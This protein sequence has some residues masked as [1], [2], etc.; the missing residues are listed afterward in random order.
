MLPRVHSVVEM[1]LY[2][3]ENEFMYKRLSSNLVPS[4]FIIVSDVVHIRLVK[5]IQLSCQLGSGR[6]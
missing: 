5:C 2:E 1:D 4:P 6:C 3:N